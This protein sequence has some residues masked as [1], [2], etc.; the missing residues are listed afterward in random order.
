MSNRYLLK[1]AGLSVEDKQV[2]KSFAST[3]LFDLPVSAVG[4]WAGHRV[5]L[6]FRNPGRGTFI[7]GHI[8]GGLGTLA[9]LKLSL[10]GKVKTVTE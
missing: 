8:G 9:A 4:A 3:A 7:G 6:R 5:G 1:I 10:H 2:A